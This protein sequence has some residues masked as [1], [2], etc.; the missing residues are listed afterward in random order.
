MKSAPDA[1]LTRVSRGVLLLLGPSGS[2]KGTM[3]DKLLEDGLITAHLSMGALLRG[4]IERAHSSSEAREHLESWLP[5]ER[6][7]EADRLD[8][9]AWL[10]HCVERGLLIPDDWTKAVI[11]RE[12]EANHELRAAPWALDGYPRR[13]AAADHLLLTLAHL[14]IPVWAVV[15]LRL[16]LEQVQAR[17]KARGRAD[18]TQEAISRRWAFYEREVVPTLAHLGSRL[19]TNRVIELEAHAPG[20]SSAESVQRVY[21]ELLERLSNLGSD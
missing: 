6:P 16:S 5:G 14:E 4:A 7:P 3:A 10:E 20:V 15:H 8:R 12:L 13:I 21:A 11:E 19:G 17:L 18:D 2:G 1:Q 9:V